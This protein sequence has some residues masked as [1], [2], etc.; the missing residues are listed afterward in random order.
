MRNSIV[1]V[2]FFA[3]KLEGT[4]LHWGIWLYNLTFFMVP[5]RSLSWTVHLAQWT[6]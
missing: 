2:L 6:Q 3:I 4:T 1:F 5:Q